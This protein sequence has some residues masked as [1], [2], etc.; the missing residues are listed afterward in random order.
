M[1]CSPKISFPESDKR[2]EFIGLAS[3]CGS[4]KT[5]GGYQSSRSAA[6]ALR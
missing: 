5:G 3:F 2:T 4:G 1:L 6:A